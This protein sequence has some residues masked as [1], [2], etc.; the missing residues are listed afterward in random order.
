[1]GYY[2]DKYGF[3]K[4]DFPV[5]LSWGNGTLSIPLFPG[6]TIQEQDYVIEV[7]VNKI[8][9]MVGESK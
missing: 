1:M 2:E 4:N 8:D 6:M 9:K 7:L 5:S 3:E